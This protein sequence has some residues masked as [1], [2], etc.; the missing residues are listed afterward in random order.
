MEEYLHLKGT[1]KDPRDMLNQSPKSN[2]GAH[3]MSKYKHINLKYKYLY[4]QQYAYS[5][6][7]QIYCFLTFLGHIKKARKG[8]MYP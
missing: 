2:A 5:L 6:C 7:P 4:K 3:C 1:C 8:H